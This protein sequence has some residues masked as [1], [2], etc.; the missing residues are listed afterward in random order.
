MRGLL[1][2]EVHGSSEPSVGGIPLPSQAEGRLSS[3]NALPNVGRGAPLPNSSGDA[4]AVEETS[5]ETSTK[6]K[7]M[8]F[9]S[10][11]TFRTW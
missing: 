8:P 9:P 10:P 2:R 6:L 11:S 4:D 5:N 1:R 3:G 7:S